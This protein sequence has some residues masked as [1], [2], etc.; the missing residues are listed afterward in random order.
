APT[1]KSALTRAVADNLFKLM[2]YKDE[3][4]VARLMT[5]RSFAN[6]IAAQ[7]EGD[8]QLHYHLAPPLLARRN[9]CGELQKSR[10]GPSTRWA[11]ELLARCKWLRGTALDLFGRSAERQQ[12][13]SLIA[14]YR[15]SMQEV[16]RTLAPHN[17]A[18]A[19]LLAS[20]PQQIK[21]YGHVKEKSIHGT[22]A[23]WSEA[24]AAFRAAKP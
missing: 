18:S 4:E 17:H 24:M 13:R 8:F 3:Y 20:V 14:D 1:G 12:E 11:F 7:F 2:A 19:L 15:T 9:A 16:M 23:K 21:G 22:R 6:R 5:D 10:F